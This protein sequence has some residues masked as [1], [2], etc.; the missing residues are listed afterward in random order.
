MASGLRAALNMEKVKS[1]EPSV[2]STEELTDAQ[3]TESNTKNALFTMAMLFIKQE[4]A[5]QTLAWRHRVLN[6]LQ[7]MVLQAT[8]NHP[9]WGLDLY[10][11]STTWCVIAKL[12]Q[13]RLVATDHLIF[14]EVKIRLILHL[15]FSSLS[16]IVY[17]NKN[18]NFV[19]IPIVFYLNKLFW[20]C[21]V[22]FHYL[23]FGLVETF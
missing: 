6:A 5:I 7:I 3:L 21:V 18:F 9:R 10:L 13:Q 19:C 4:F 16:E 17:V 14:L 12:I 2:V 22:V 23:Y 1:K 8:V 20:E 11:A 15:L